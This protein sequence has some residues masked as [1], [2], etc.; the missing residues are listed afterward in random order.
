MQGKLIQDLSFSNES[1]LQAISLNKQIPSGVYFI[2]AYS[3]NGN[4]LSQ[5][6]ILN[7]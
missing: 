2:Q 3:N 4:F 6:L 1:N 5:K 7:R